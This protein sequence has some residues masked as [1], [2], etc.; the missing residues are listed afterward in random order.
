LSDIVKVSRK[1][2]IT[3]PARIRRRFNIEPGT[4]LRFIETE[5]DFRITLAPKGITSLLGRVQVEGP[6]DFKAVRRA[7]MEDRVDARTARD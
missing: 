2:Q 3:L 4:Y 6:Q 5:D 7:A 1:G